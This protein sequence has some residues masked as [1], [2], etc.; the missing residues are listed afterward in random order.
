MTI[1]FARRR[2]KGRPA[3]A[4]QRFWTATAWGQPATFALIAI[5]PLTG[6]HDHALIAWII[7]TGMA[8]GTACIS[9]PDKIFGAVFRYCAAVLMAAVP[10]LHVIRW[11]GTAQDGIAWFIDAVLLASAGLIALLARR[12]RY[13]D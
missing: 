10:I 1:W 11:S 7:M 4:W 2:D 5:L 9:I 3:L 6:V 13:A 12:R 8:Y